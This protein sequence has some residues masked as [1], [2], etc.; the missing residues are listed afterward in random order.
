MKRIPGIVDLIFALSLCVASACIAAAPL[1]VSIVEPAAGRDHSVVIA[2]QTMRMSGTVSG[3]YQVKSVLW[4]SS[5]GFSDLAD[6]QAFKGDAG[7]IQW[8]TRPIPVLP[9]ANHID[10]VVTD[11]QGRGAETSIN[12][13]STAN[14]P[15]TATPQIRSSFYHG[16]PVTYQVSNGLAIYEGDIVL[17]TADALE[18]ARL[19]VLQA[20][21]RKGPIADSAAIAYQSG[22]WPIISGVGRVPFTISAR[23]QAV[24]SAL[25]NINSA[26]MQFDTQLAGVVQFVP[27]TPEDADYAEF[28][29]DPTDMS[30][31][32]EASE[33]YQ[34]TAGQ[35]VGGSILCTV[36]TILHEM[37]HVIGLWHEQS[38][39]DRSL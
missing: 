36:P 20:P 34:A 5:R 16:R 13:T 28:D 12:I 9:G 11:S 6:I 18:A 30:G 22:R 8:I 3:A 35:L 21:E 39:S 2:R 19:Q 31:V 4:K 17:G 10:V 32:R 29:L 15:V 7:D 25:A 23:D 33:G 1:S 37:G 38:R 24:A 27:A 14:V 26:I